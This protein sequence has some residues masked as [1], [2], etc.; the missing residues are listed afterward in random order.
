MDDAV[1]IWV[2]LEDVFESLLARNVDIVVIW[3][4]AADELHSVQSLRGRIV[5]VVDDNDMVA[6]FKES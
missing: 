1:D 2:L 3:L 6:R 5:E 4:L